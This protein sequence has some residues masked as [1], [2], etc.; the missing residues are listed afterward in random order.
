[1][2]TVLSISV[3]FMILALAVQ[4]ASAANCARA[5]KQLAASRGAQVLASTPVSSG[6]QTICQV[7][8]LIPGK[9][10]KPPRVETLQV[11]G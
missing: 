10:G 1:M 7:K 5:A 2:K 9:N 8:L 11:N 4:S 6:G 3:S